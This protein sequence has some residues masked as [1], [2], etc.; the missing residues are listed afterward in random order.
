[1]DGPAQLNDRSTNQPINQ[2]TDQPT[3]H[4]RTT[5][6]TALSALTRSRDLLMPGLKTQMLTLVT[7]FRIIICLFCHADP[8]ISQKTKELKPN[9]F[10]PIKDNLQTKKLSDANLRY[11]RSL[12]LGVKIE[13]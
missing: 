8:K 7:R 11:F 3:K 5:L 13:K 9:R 4:C 12:P 2:L 1:M 10:N 6:L